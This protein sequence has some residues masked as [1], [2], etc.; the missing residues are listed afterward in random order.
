[1]A[2]MLVQQ[3]QQ[4]TL[5]TPNMTILPT[6]S[7]TNRNLLP[8]S[9]SV[10]DRLFYLEQDSNTFF[11]LLQKF[12]SEPHISMYHSASNAFANKNSLLSPSLPNTFLSLNQ[13]E[14]EQEQ[15]EVNPLNCDTIQFASTDDIKSD[16]FDTVSLTTTTKKLNKVTTLDT[17]LSSNSDRHFRR[18][19]RRSS[20]TPTFCSSIDEDA[21]LKT[22][23]IEK[24]DNNQEEE[25]PIVNDYVQPISFEKLS[26]E[27]N[28]TKKEDT[29]EDHETPLGTEIVLS[30]LRPRRLRF[31]LS[32]QTIPSPEPIPE[33]NVQFFVPTEIPVVPTPIPTPST[34]PPS[35]T[36]PAHLFQVQILYPV[37]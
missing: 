34:P 14:D 35:P 5:R 27:D 2:H 32:R 29:S 37:V 13:V 33:N 16:T 22:D 23:A 9:H 4:Q 21:S 36:S 7:T 10:D 20:W 1:M 25:S 8:T 17:I 12:A 24:V 30:R 19:K 31:R 11:R 26:L 18:R 3:Q 28:N 6:T 15:N